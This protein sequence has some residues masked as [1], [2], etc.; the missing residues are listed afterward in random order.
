MFCGKCGKENL[1]NAMFCSNCGGKLNNQNLAGS[2]FVL[3]VNPNNK[4]QK[5]GI[6]AIIVAV[7][8]AIIIVIALFGGRGYKATVKKFINAQFEGDADAIIDIIP[9]EMVEYII[10][11]EYDDEDEMLEE[12]EEEIEYYLDEIEEQFGKNWKFSYEI[13]DTDDVKGDDL[14]DLQ[15]EYEDVGIEVSAAKEVEIKI[16]FESKDLDTSNNLDI[17]LI[18]VGRS[19][20]IDFESVF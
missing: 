8:I 15:D 1:D 14:E 5:V 12:L 11:E 18:K 16:E 13:V 7:I 9:D 4:N 3:P 17:G 2:E 6:I 10:E 19:W 20:Y